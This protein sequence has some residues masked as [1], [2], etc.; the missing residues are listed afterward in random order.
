MKFIRLVLFILLITELAFADSATSSDNESDG[1]LSVEDKKTLVELNKQIKN[2]QEQIQQQ[3]NGISSNSSSGEQF[4]TYS[5]QIGE[6]LEASNNYLDLGD[7]NIR[8]ANKSEIESDVKKG[9]IIEDGLN[10]EKNPLGGGIFSSSGGIDT[11]NTPAI[12]TRGE[13]AYLGSY[14]GNNTIPIGMISSNLFAS[15]LLGQ[16]Q[17]FD[18][19]SVFFGGYIEA[20]AQNWFGSGISRT[21]GKS[22]FPAN[23]QNMYLTTSKLYFVSNVGH[24]VTAQIDFD[25]D[26]T[27]GFGVGNAFVMFGNLD[28]SPFFVTAG[29]SKLSVGSYGGGGPWTSGIID[30]F[31]SPD[32]VTN[33][34][35]NYK[36]DVINAN[37]T[38]F[39]SDDK[40]ANFSTAIFYADS[41]TENLS[42]G[43]NAG[44]V[45]NIS[46]SGNGSISQFLEKANREEDNVGVI[47]FDANLAYAMLGGVWQ[48]QG[49]W[50]T[51]TR[52]EDF[53]GDGNMVNTGAWYTGLVYARNLGGKDTNFNITYGE[54]YN[55]A[56]IPMPTASAS[57]TFGSTISGI[58]NQFIA[59]AQRAYFDDNVLL[60]PEYA[61]Q[62]L[63]NGQ[64]MNTFTLDMSVYL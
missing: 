17:R 54:S 29:K 22:S 42:A 5:D 16:K 39:G 60:G 27:G 45:Y 10:E 7:D 19:Y 58:K 18:D 33:L 11:R 59:S 55:A 36:N 52:K 48:I 51:T 15:T 26:E 25:T 63:Y 62:K 23:G 30:E 21:N 20:D 53:N 40:R 49:G 46:G 4:N 6:T 44:Y 1:S 28:T 3:E 24:Y 34:A 56:M 50:S 2:L 31:L 47:N 13:V 37:I 32:K 12:T 9:S 57:P 61:Y 41:W 43:F 35:L 64:Y 38:A 14:S 8:D